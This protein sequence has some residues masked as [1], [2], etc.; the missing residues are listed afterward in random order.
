MPREVLDYLI[1]TPGGRYVDGTLGGGGHTRLILE[2]N[3]QA[4]VLGI[5]RDKDAVEAASV[6]LA[7]FG[8][9][10]RGVQGTY[11]ELGQFITEVGWESVHG[12]LVD[13]G[14]SSHQVDTPERGFS[15]RHDGPL[16]MRFDRTQTVTAAT[17]LNTADQDELVRIFR[18]Y[19]EERRARSVA[20]AVVERRARRPWARTRELTELLER[21]VG[22]RHGERLP[23]STRCFQALR[24]AVNRELDE[25]GRGLE[26]AETA[27]IAGGRLV[28]ISFHSLE[29]RIV[30]HAFRQAATTCVCPPEFPVCRCTKKATLRILTK[31][32]LRPAPDEIAANSRANPAK[33][34]AAVKL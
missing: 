7:E 16:D 31:R 33:L 8:P 30:K 14:L 15:F 3:E 5:D 13:A 4:E 21:V 26:A 28:V 18:N 10:F 9:R 19:G 11:S 17:I 2:A 32:P 24:I 1:A 25:L 22:R 6:E 23:P 29:D 20:R 34:R 12:V 27:L